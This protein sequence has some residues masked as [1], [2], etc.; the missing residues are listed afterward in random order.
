M[1]AWN[2]LFETM[3]YESD[4]TYPGHEE[5]YGNGYQYLP[6]SADTG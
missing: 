4:N 2:K 6:K 1:K 5:T 3:K